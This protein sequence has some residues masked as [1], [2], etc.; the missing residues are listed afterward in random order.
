MNFTQAIDYHVRLSR[1]FHASHCPENAQ[2]ELQDALRIIKEMRQRADAL[3]ARLEAARP[4]L[5]PACQGHG[6][7]QVQPTMDPADIQEE[8]CRDC[9]GTGR[10]Q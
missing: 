8:D 2:R 4:K 5:C 6:V 10:R 3:C 9:G 1:E 7:I